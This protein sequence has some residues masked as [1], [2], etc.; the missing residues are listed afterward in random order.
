MLK[1]A[2][3]S[4]IRQVKDGTLGKHL[5]N[6]RVVGDVWVTESAKAMARE[7]ISRRREAQGKPP[8]PLEPDPWF[9]VDQEG[10]RVYRGFGV[11]IVGTGEPHAIGYDFMMSSWSKVR[12]LCHCPRDTEAAGSFRVLG[13]AADRRYCRGT[14]FHFLRG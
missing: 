14:R 10:R 2:R 13:S 4:A 6:P 3:H 1:A 5:T 9:S 7:I 8:R 11:G 12:T